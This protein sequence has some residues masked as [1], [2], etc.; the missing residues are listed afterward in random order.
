MQGHDYLGSDADVNI[1]FSIK[2]LVPR[3]LYNDKTGHALCKAIERAFQ[4]VAEGA[5]YGLDIIQDPEKMPEWRLDELANELNCVYDY[6]A[7]VES[8]R[9]WIAN[10]I[11]LYR[12]YGTP[13]AI[14]SFLEGAF[15]TVEVEEAWQYGG[16]PFHFRVTVS[17]PS[18]D[19]EK[20]AWAQKAI[21]GVKNVRSILDTV[22]L[23]SSAEILV[24]A[25]T[26]YFYV[27]YIYA[28][29]DEYTGANDIEDWDVPGDTAR[30]DEAL[31]DEGVTG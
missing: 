25:D 12:E 29:D 21:S 28:S 18:Y 30:A 22:L 3:F 1:A 27:P 6:K 11:Q 16:D 23:D 20:I 24:S 5:Q 10:A 13:Q 4:M 26:D 17:G 7:D 19:A 9:Y 15:Q 31:T 8:K 14:I 2:R